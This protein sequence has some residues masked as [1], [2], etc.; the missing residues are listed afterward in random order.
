[1]PMMRPLARYLPALMLSGGAVLLFQTHQQKA[2]PLRG[3]LEALPDTMLGYRGFNITVSQEEQ[4]VAGMSSYGFRAFTRDSLV[5]FSVY[6]GYYES[7]AQGRTIHSPKN[8]L[9]GAGWEPVS[10]GTMI[11][12]AR[13]TA[14][15]VNRYL[16]SKGGAYA[17]VYYWYQGRSRV[18][19]DE[20][21][22]KLDLMRD[23][24]TAGRSE[25]ALARIV[26][27]FIDGDEAGADSLAT[28]VASRV[29]P[30]LFDI[31]PTYR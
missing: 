14:Y 13:D 26:V 7:Q 21:Q 4:R 2:V 29:I 12:P 31:L 10:A 1:M 27:P 3:T 9:P 16:I 25:E 23:K 8:C 20:F 28:A 22:V 6:V 15:T 24:A 5:R 11:I 17:V 19:W 30:S 18:A